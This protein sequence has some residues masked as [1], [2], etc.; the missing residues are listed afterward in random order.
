MVWL[1]NKIWSLI[2]NQLNKIRIIIFWMVVVLYSAK[3]L[4]DTDF[5]Y[6]TENILMDGHCLLPYT[7]ECCIVF[8]QFDGLN[9]DGLAEKRQ[10]FALYSKLWPSHLRK[11]KHLSSCFT[12]VSHSTSSVNCR[13]IP[14]RIMTR[15]KLLHSTC[16]FYN[17]NTNFLPLIIR[18]GSE[19]S[20]FAC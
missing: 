12:Y 4:T 19:I 18:E 5:K 7:C 9:F 2:Y 14:I 3:F 17:Y 11:P 8:K 6:L 10:N 15:N 20:N 16:S 13:F 1:L